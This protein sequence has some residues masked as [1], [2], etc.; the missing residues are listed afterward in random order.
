MNNRTIT[1]MQTRYEVRKKQQEN[2]LLRE[3]QQAQQAELQAQ[4]YRNYLLGGGLLFG[5][6]LTGTMAWSWS[7][8]KQKN[9]KISEQAAVLDRQN[10]Q[11]KKMDA[12]KDR[13]LHMIV[14]DM[15]NPLSVIVGMAK[16]KLLKRS[17]LQMKALINNILEVEKLVQARITTDMETIKIA[18][19]AEELQTQMHPIFDTSRQSLDLQLA[20]DLEVR[21]DYH[22]LYRTLENLLS[23]ASKYSSR[24]STI[25]LSAGR[26][27]NSVR[28]EV[29]DDGDGI[30]EHQQEQIFEQYWSADNE[31]RNNGS[32]D[33]SMGLG[34]AF[35]K[36]A[37]DAQK[38]EIGIACEP[39]QGTTFWIRL[40]A[41]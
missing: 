15:R 41:A 6:V 19:M 26:Q 11:L 24:D 25:T 10:E 38:G 40:P 35:C 34:L 32:G 2:A 39:G 12:F 8:Q 21:A 14:H 37:V 7:R 13:M 29:I 31:N 9:R 16:N 23:N 5:L 33:I 3:Q 20:D 18:E 4:R 28:I 17:G 22:L 27:Q 1:E 30:P 36:M